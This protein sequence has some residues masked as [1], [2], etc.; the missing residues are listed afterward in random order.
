MLAQ[1]PVPLLLAYAVDRVESPAAL[2]AAGLGAQAFAVAVL[3]TG[4]V[5]PHRPIARDVRLTLLAGGTVAAGFATMSAL[6]AAYLED[7]SV[8]VG[9]ALLVVFAAGT[10]VVAEL[11]QRR[12]PSPDGALTS[13]PAALSGVAAA[14]LVAAAWAPVVDAV[15][16]ALARGRA[17]R[18]G[19]RPA[20]GRV[21]GAGR[22]S[23]GAR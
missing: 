3:V 16:V 19:P 20:G 13:V 5:L 8:L 22:S 6:V 15:P 2:V 12:R 14:L 10:G 7:D 9:S 1:L 18:D 21:A 23:P 11:V 17:R 4:L